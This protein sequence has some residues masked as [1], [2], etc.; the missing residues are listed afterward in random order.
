MLILSK[1]IKRDS[2]LLTYFTPLDYTR[3][4][5]ADFTDFYMIH[6]Y[7][8][9]VFSALNY[10]SDTSKLPAGPIVMGN[11]GFPASIDS[12]SDKMALF[13]DRFQEKN[14]ISGFFIESFRDW[15][16]A[17]VN[18]YSPDNE[19]YP[20]GIYRQ[21]GTIRPHYREISRIIEG[22]SPATYP[23][24][25]DRNKKS[26]LFSLS[27][28]FTT[29]L[30]FLIYRR[31]FRLRDNI[32]RSLSHSYGFFVD[33]RDRRII[34]LFNSFIIG[35]FSNFLI[36]NIITAYLYYFRDSLYIEEVISAT[37]V[38]LGLDRIFTVLIQYPFILL[39]LIWGIFFAGQILIASILRILN[40]FS[41]EKIR[42]RQTVAVCNW[43]GVPLLFLIPVSLIS[44]H[45]IMP[46]EYLHLYLFFILI[47]FFIWYNFRL[48]NGIR[49]L[50][51]LQA[52]KV[53]SILVL[54]YCIVLFI[55][56]AFL[57]SQSDYIDYINLLSGAQSLFY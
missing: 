25:V 10:F 46:R 15:P 18:Y 35:L 43:A 44:Y 54:T 12:V 21:N 51:I 39:L 50:M 33:L 47:F 57:E 30:F 23:R 5:H 37:L 42:F 34:A 17:V 6:A 26:N 3:I 52:Y 4:P 9:A 2:Q 14:R 27:V 22:K 53:F 11:V 55:L 36:A 16:A 28:F 13:N 40:I 41:D 7:H 38:P 56:L 20:Y 1:Y 45:F 29:I 49:V 8:E 48:A 31:N 24:G 19:Y 32:K